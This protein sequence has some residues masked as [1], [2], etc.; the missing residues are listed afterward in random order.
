MSIPK[1]TQRK[2]EKIFCTAE[3]RKRAKTIRAE[4]A[5]NE[6]SRIILL[7]RSGDGF[8]HSDEIDHDFPGVFLSQKHLA[9]RYLIARVATS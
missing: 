6:S 8:L 9:E 5:R 7:A 1:A 3:E 2:P 4:V